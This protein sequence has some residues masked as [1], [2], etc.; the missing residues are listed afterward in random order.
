MEISFG[1]RLFLIALFSFIIMRILY[2]YFYQ[3]LNLQYIHI[4][5][6][7]PFLKQQKKPL[8]TSGSLSTTP[9][10]NKSFRNNSSL[11]RNRSSRNVSSLLL[12]KSA[13]LAMIGSSGA[14]VFNHTD[15]SSLNSTLSRKKGSRLS[16]TK[17]LYEEWENRLTS[18]ELSWDD[19]VSLPRQP[20]RLK[21]NIPLFATTRL[22]QCENTDEQRNSSFNVSL[23]RRG[24]NDVSFLRLH[25]VS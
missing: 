10:S 5:H 25:I 21:Q 13:K 11:L 23:N 16:R 15:G 3:Y 17:S 2:I 20:P 19:F 7:E 12:K 18:K 4:H 8:S 14:L 9:L 22:K 1:K 6:D 24:C